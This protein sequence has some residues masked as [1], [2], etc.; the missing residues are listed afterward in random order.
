MNESTELLEPLVQT[1]DKCDWKKASACYRKTFATCASTLSLKPFGG[2]QI[3][4]PSSSSSGLFSNF[5]SGEIIIV[6]YHRHSFSEIVV[7]YF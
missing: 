4:T 1:R 3:V 2:A 6:F 7:I 5:K